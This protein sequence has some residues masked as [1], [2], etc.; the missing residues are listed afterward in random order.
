[1]NNAKT[2]ENNRSCKKKIDNGVTIVFHSVSIKKFFIWIVIL[3]IK[4]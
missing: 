2:L 4:R 3:S 1:M